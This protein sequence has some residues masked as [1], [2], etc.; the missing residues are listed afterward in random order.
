MKPIIAV[1]FSCGAPSAIAAKLTLQ[2]YGEAYDVLIVNTPIAEEDD[3][4]KRFFTG[5]F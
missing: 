5:R 2:H 3:D 4:N 1:W